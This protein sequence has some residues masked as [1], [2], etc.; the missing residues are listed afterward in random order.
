LSLRD[1]I[2]VEKDNKSKTGSLVRDEIKIILDRCDK[3]IFY[4]GKG[5][6]IALGFG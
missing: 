5:Y 6:K 1:R 4:L 3:N 2:F